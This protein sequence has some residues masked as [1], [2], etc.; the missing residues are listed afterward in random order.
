MYWEQE[1]AKMWT[2]WKTP[3]YAPSYLIFAMYPLHANTLIHALGCGGALT[4]SV[5]SFTSP[6]YPLPYHPN[7]ECYWHIKI[8]AGSKI[9]LSFGHFHLES[10]TGCLY[11]YLA[12]RRDTHFTLTV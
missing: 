12:V 7:A 6:N 9:Q 4:T 1:E 5:G 2:V 3:S 10:S 8:S 11:D